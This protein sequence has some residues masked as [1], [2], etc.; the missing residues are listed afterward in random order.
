MIFLKTIHAG[1]YPTST[2]I[3]A[4]GCKKVRRVYFRNI[5]NVYTLHPFESIIDFSFI[6]CA[7]KL[8]NVIKV[9]EGVRVGK[10]LREL[11]WSLLMLSSVWGKT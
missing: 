8:Q 7:N 2:I 6:L 10:I 1:G 3:G 9:G 4:I 5:R 11:F